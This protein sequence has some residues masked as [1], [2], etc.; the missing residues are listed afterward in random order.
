MP[1]RAARGPLPSEAM[2]CRNPF[3]A[4]VASNKLAHRDLR[5]SG[6]IRYM[7]PWLCDE[8]DEVDELFGGD[9]WPFGL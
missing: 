1:V 3:K 5:F 6:A 4:F 2:D 7:V 9:A 8:I